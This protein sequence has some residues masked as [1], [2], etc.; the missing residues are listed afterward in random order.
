MKRLLPKIRKKPPRLRTSNDYVKTQRLLKNLC[1]EYFGRMFDDSD[2]PEEL[3]EYKTECEEQIT[4]E[5]WEVNVAINNC[6]K[7]TS[8]GA[9]GISYLHISRLIEDSHISKL[10]L[11]ALTHWSNH[12]LPEEYKYALIY[13]IPKG[14]RE[15]DGY[16]PI[17]LLSCVS[18]ILEKVM[19]KRLEPM[20]HPY[21]P[22]TQC[23]CMPG[24]TAQDCVMRLTQAS[25]R[26]AAN[27]SK[28][29]VVFLDFS[30]AFDLVDRKLLMK[31]LEEKFH[32]PEP[33]LR[34]IADW[35]YGRTFGVKFNNEVSEVHNT[36]RG[37]PQG[38][39]LSVLLWLVYISD[40][41]AIPSQ[42]AVF[43][44]DTA[45]WSQSDSEDILVQELTGSLDEIFDWCKRNNV[46]VN[47]GK[48]K[49]IRN[50]Y[51]FR[52]KIYPEM[53][54]IECTGEAKYLGFW[55][56]SGD[57]DDSQILFDFSGVAADIRR[58]ASILSPVAR[59]LRTKDL[60]LF[61]NA[62]ILS[63]LRYYTPLMAAEGDTGRLECIKTA[64]NYYMR[65]LTGA[66]YSTR[67]SLLHAQSSIPD[68]DSIISNEA[69][70]YYTRMIHH[71]EDRLYQEYQRWDGSESASSPLLGV[72][73]ADVEFN[74]CVRTSLP[75]DLHTLERKESRMLFK[76][77]F[78]IAETRKDALCL[79]DE[80]LLVPDGDIS[81]WTDGSYKPRTSQHPPSAGGGWVID[82]KPSRRYL[83]SNIK[84][85]PPMSSY[86]SEEGAMIAA[87]EYLIY[88]GA[89]IQGRSIVILS[90]SRSLITHLKSLKR[91]AKRCEF[92]SKLLVGM[93]CRLWSLCPSSVKFVWV[94]GH[95]KIG[96]N[97]KADEQANAGHASHK[98]LKLAF[99]KSW[100]KRWNKESTSEDFRQF[101]EENVKNSSL[102][103]GY[104]N[105]DT[106][107]N[108]NIKLTNVFPRQK[109]G[110]IALFRMRTGH[111][112]T[113]DHVNRLGWAEDGLLCRH[114]GLA[115]E[116][117]KHLTLEC[118]RYI[119]LNY[120]SRTRLYGCARGL[121]LDTTYEV[122]VTYRSS[123]LES[124]W[125]RLLLDLKNFGVAL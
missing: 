87:M 88:Y 90:D 72:Y 49:Y 6:K 18:K 76:T 22:T 71:K 47:M 81:I 42:S 19:T 118:E 31:K 102:N 4:I 92:N 77:Q 20:I 45:I 104:P 39:S 16:R 119:P 106:F 82:D 51:K 75:E 10:F 38:S 52:H 94:P 114:C 109:W 63:K 62:L 79:H 61:G 74:N 24:R 80:G 103:I 115:L 26:A 124:C 112:N 44:D 85:E 100:L 108:P 89:Y 41:P 30:K 111:T 73:E 120:Y 64:L 21:L 12:G 27:N 110:Q 69:R 3:L 65:V 78:E 23:G 99:P 107:Q 86:I 60:K 97:P 58:R 11:S 48:T 67:I 96:M 125:I 95:S 123:K 113:R 9:D 28:F 98:I 53:G 15:V 93:L 32:I 121:N 116:S 46:I 122:M 17:S 40:I 2:D 117:A 37:I 14:R 54:T 5:E 34:Y 91:L 66:F 13:P 33:Y 1:A 101:L 70:R 55:L 59:C 36:T 56:T 50:E 57:S 25:S 105:R 68:L 7:R 83:E 43:M 35:L 29:G 8:V 84:I